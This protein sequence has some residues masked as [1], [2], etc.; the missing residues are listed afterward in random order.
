MDP[1]AE[2]LLRELAQAP[3]GGPVSLPRLGKRLG[4][5]VSVLMRQLT[6][7]GEASLGG[8]AGPGLVR[9]TQLDDRWVAALTD[10]GRAWC[11]AQLPE[12]SEGA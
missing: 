8:V 7:L 3:N 4:Q 10:A 9:V 11:D 2:A 6:L 5:G 12:R 1:L